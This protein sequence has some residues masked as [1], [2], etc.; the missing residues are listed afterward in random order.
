MTAAAV[1]VNAGAS[2]TAG[3]AGALSVTADTLT[4]LG[5]LS[6]GSTGIV[7]L[8][9]FT[10][11]RNI[12]LG[13]TGPSTDL[14]LPDSALGQ[15]TAG[16]LR[17]GDATA[18]TGNITITDSVSSHPG[19]AT[20]FLQTQ[21]GSINEA[22]GAT[23]TVANLAL[24][25]GSG[26]GTTGDLHTAVTNL[27]FAN[28]SGAIHI[29]NTGAV[30]LTGV[31][32]LIGSSIPGNIDSSSVVGSVYTLVHSSG[33][34]S[35][36]ISYNGRALAEGATL[37]LADGNR[38]QISYKAG[39]GQDVTLTRIA[40]VAGAKVLGQ[41][42]RE[43]QSVGIGFWADAAGQAL[44]RSF[45]GGPTS[46]ALAD[47][48]AATLPNLYGAG[49]GPHDVTG[50]TNAQVAALVRKLSRARASRPEA[51]VLATAMDVYA[52]TRSL[53]GTAARRDG[54]RVT[55]VGLGAT[56]Y[57]IGARGAA[58][59][60]RSQT[61]L[62]VDQILAAANESAVDAALDNGNATLRH[63]ADE[64]FTEIN[65]GT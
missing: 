28:Q 9:P 53:G 54:F 55:A 16:T 56:A 34:V 45:N 43:G 63:R 52:T 44:I 11:T 39:G 5:T 25:A 42:I 12:D 36:Q 47:W 57:T 6:A 38:Y 49:T 20:L 50:L 4:L 59:G 64:L 2:V 61:V 32:T 29:S 37:V 33:G 35:G 60:V 18:D 65:T 17:I 46:P 21:K 14:V 40:T 3:T 30:T 62:D 23:L 48:L 24:Q 58:L 51:Q 7:T 22:N 1:T 19:Y 10:T 26:I 8:K 27:A 41:P 15:V 13:G 31:D